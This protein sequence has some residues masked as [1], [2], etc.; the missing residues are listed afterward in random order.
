MLSFIL[1]KNSGS[2]AAKWGNLGT[3]LCVLGVIS[4]AVS[5]FGETSQTSLKLHKLPY[6]VYLIT[7]SLFSYG[8]PYA[9]LVFAMIYSGLVKGKR[10]K[11]M[12]LLLL[13]P[14]VIN[15]I[16][17]PGYKSGLSTQQEYKDFYTLVCIWAVPYLAAF[18]TL[19]LASYFKE[20]NLKVK[21]QKFV[22]A[23]MIAPFITL[24]MT[25]T[26]IMAIWGIGKVMGI[27]WLLVLQFI[28]FLL[29]VAKYG[30]MGI[31]F[32][33]ETDKMDST[34][35]AVH[36]STALLNQTLKNEVVK[37]NR[38]MEELK[39][40]VN[41]E[42]IDDTAVYKN[43]RTVLNTTVHLADMVN[44]IQ[45]KI[46]DVTIVEEYCNIQELVNQ[47]LNG[48]SQSIEDKRITVNQK[49]APGIL[50][51]CDRTHTKEVLLNLFRNAVEA[52][53]Q[54]GNIY[55]ET[56]LFKNDFTVF[57]KDNGKGISKADLPHVLE[58]FF[59]TSGDPQNLGLGLSYCYNILK[60][61][62]GYIE[63][64]SRENI[65]TAVLLSFPARRV[66]IEKNHYY[67]VSG[68]I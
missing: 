30:F 25:K 47:A 27:D 21:K 12:P 56:R 41:E 64:Q 16:L 63:I 45:Q 68:G 48:V 18:N 2:K 44:R 8:I 55:I 58:P 35:K 60:K 53:Q 37:I 51:L 34:M 11:W 52:L 65:G 32:K 26:Y 23:V 33:F 6:T 38:S 66:V 28:T 15:I 10:V 59:T 43:I 61:H 1:F 3:F 49:V 22:M 31:Q 46:S 42:I 20:R 50:L 67:A 14:I 13:I 9:M 39:S 36:T 54:G 57:V 17:Y 29:Y 5:Y 24:G 4:I 40:D 62:Q 7:N 19:L